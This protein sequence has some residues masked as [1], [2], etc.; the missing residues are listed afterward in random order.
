[1]A[2]KKAVKRFKQIK[3]DKKILDA[4]AEVTKW[5]KNLTK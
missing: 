3:D 4:L 1:M 5:V 2:H